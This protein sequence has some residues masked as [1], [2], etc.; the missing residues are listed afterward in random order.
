MPELLNT[1]VKVHRIT[2]AQVVMRGEI[3][4]VVRVEFSVGEHGPF[5][6]DFLP[7]ESN[8][9]QVHMRLN[10]WAARLLAIGGPRP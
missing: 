10:G 6:E 7:A 4:N 5:T 1:A 8:P 9:D 2:Q 3:A